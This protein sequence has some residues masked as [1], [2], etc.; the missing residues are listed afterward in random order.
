MCIR[1]SSSPMAL[2]PPALLLLLLPMAACVNHQ[3]LAAPAYEVRMMNESDPSQSRSWPAPHYQ[4]KPMRTREGERYKCYTPTAQYD[5]KAMEARGVQHPG[6]HPGLNQSVHRLFGSCHRWKAKG[7]FWRYEVCHGNKVLQYHQPNPSLERTQ[8]NVL[9]LYLK[10]TTDNQGP[11]HV[12]QAGDQCKLPSGKSK[13]RAVSV[14]FKCGKEWSMGPRNK[15][16]QAHGAIKPGARIADMEEV[17]PCMYK[18]VVFSPLAC[19]LSKE[20]H[21][22]EAEEGAAD[23]GTPKSPTELIKRLHGNCVHLGLGWWSYE[24]CIGK[25]LR[26]M[27][28][29]NDKV[30]T[31]YVL[32]NYSSDT[33]G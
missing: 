4:M 13:R 20:P 5:H 6:Y 28:L 24:L 16:I 27:H 29:Q 19:T 22:A 11:I 31:E 18:M 10:N 26:Q 15:L 21:T 17:G 33:G 12:Y 8:V 9:G 23:Q 2:Q 32:G 30:E 7:E 1:D 14:H 3:S 25:H